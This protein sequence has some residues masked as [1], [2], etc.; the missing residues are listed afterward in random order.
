MLS[1]ISFTFSKKKESKKYMVKKK[2]FVGVI[3]SYYKELS[4]LLYSLGVTPVISLKLRL[5]ERAEE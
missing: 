2:K 3:Y 5:K 4:L 1:I